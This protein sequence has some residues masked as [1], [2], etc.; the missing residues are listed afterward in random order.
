MK[1]LLGAIIIAVIM[2]AEL[3]AAAPGMSRQA[4]FEHAAQDLLDFI[5]LR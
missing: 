1:S 4:A 5:G 3:S 2:L